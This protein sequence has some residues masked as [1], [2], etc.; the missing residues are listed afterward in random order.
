M[1]NILIIDD[2]Y[3]YREF[4]VT[5]VRRQGHAAYDLPNGLGVLEAVTEF[6]IDLV[7]TDIFMPV[8]D[9]IEVLRN[10]RTYR[11][12]MPVIALTGEVFDISDFY[13]RTAQRFGAV[14]V[15]VKPIKPAELIDCIA[16]VMAHAA[17]EKDFV[18]TGGR[19]NG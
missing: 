10:L 13:G 3:F 6:A 7:I 19:A 9:G 1:A 15:L 16:D 11:P 17:R 2:D 14:R 12:E 18:E 5:A 8:V 4:L